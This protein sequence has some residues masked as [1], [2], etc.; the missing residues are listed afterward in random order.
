MKQIRM[1]APAFTMRQWLRMIAAALIISVF[2]WLYLF[3]LGSA[4]PLSPTEEATITNLS[5]FSA[6]IDNP[7]NLG[8]K[9]LTFGLWNVSSESTALRLRFHCRLQIRQ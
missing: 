8:Y 4:M 3:H 5:S 2:G 6:V 9:L 1:Q 7:L